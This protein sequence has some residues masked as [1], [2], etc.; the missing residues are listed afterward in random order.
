MPHSFV[1]ALFLICG[2]AHADRRA[3]AIIRAGETQLRGSTSQA[4]MSMEIKRDSYVRKLK[5]RS[6]TSGNRRA[7]VEILEPAKEEV[8]SSLRRNDQMWN[9][10][11]KIDQVV[12]VPTSL[13]LQ[14]WMGSDFTND[15]LMKASSLLRDY[16]HRISHVDR[17]KKLIL[18]QC[19]P[20]PNAPVVWGRVFYWARMKDSLPVKQAYYDDRGVLVRTVWFKRFKKM[21][22]RVIPTEVT[23]RQAGNAREYT[24]VRYA[25]VLYDRALN[26]EVFDRDRL[27]HNAQLGRA[28]SRGWAVR[29]L[30]RQAS[31]VT[32]NYRLASQP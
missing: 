20:K 7:L 4:L 16:E 2:T 3:T 6:W 27:K 8:V 28:I 10:L 26:E 18:V 21:D 22:D 19:S 13:M 15:D 12:R 24:T 5:L 9:Y 25:K 30:H 14:S 17:R 31:R 1:I 32:R 11:P 29:P 23:I